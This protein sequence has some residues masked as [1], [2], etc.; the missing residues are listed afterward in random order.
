MPEIKLTK[1]YVALVDEQDMALVSQ[2]QWSASESRSGGLQR[3]YAVREAG[4]QRIAM[5]RLIMGEPD[6]D[7]D[8]RDAA[9]TLDNRRSNLRLASR[10]QNNGNGRKRSGTTSRFKGVSFHR[11]TGKW[12]VQIGKK[13]L[14]L[15]ADEVDAATVYNFA[16]KDRFGEFARFN[17]A[18]R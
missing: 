14:A 17:V 1:G 3:V 6:A 10:S 4:G 7:V 13:H 9:A 2:F 16:A 8:H 18:S 11:Q 5:H 12:C 15:C